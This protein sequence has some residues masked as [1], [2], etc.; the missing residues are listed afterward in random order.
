M[1]RSAYSHKKI[2]RKLIDIIVITECAVIC[3]ADNWIE[4]VE[5]GDEKKD[6][7]ATF[8][9]LPNDI[10]SHDTFNRVFSRINP[11]E[12]QRR[13]AAWIRAAGEITKGQVVAMDGKT[14]RRSYDK[15]SN[16]AAIH[17]VSA[18]ASA[19]RLV[20]GQVKTDEK[21]N[22]I[23]AIPELLDFLDIKGCIVTIDA[24][25]CQKKLGAA[26]IMQ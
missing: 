8:L 11:E 14:L 19:S 26:V 13:F 12:F 25:G 22:E 3:G 10:P 9:D 16:K 20:L 5:Y 24:M 15:K 23:T 17:M 2:E 1:A 21:S 4:V 7:F 18:W 6:W